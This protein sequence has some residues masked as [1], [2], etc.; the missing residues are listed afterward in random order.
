MRRF[1][2]EIGSQLDSDEEVQYYAA[3]VDYV[4]QAG[5]GPSQ[6]LSGWIW[7]S[8]GKRAQGGGQWREQL[9]GPWVNTE[10]LHKF[11]CCPLALNT[12]A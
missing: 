12:C 7:G 5:G 8:Y 11:E 3:V 6:H 9:C 10:F 4:V 2:G 1:S